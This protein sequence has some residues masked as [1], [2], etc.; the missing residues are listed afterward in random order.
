V[1]GMPYSECRIFY[2]APIAEGD[3][4]LTSSGKTAYFVTA[5]RASPRIRRRN[6]LRCLRWPANEIP[7]GAT[8][9]RLH[10]YKR[11]RK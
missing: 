1:K 5:V 2:D 9:R 11:G 4:I 7:E 6:Y 8:V 10:W 3:Y